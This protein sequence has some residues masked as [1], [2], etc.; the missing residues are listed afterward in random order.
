MLANNNTTSLSK[1][2]EMKAKKLHLQFGHALSYKIE[3]LLIDA[4]NEVNELVKSVYKFEEKCK[5]CKTFSNAKLRPAVGLSLVKEFNENVS[6]DLMD[7]E[8]TKILHI[9][10][11]AT[12]FST[13]CII[14]SK[15]KRVIIDKVFKFW[16]AVLDVQSDFF[17]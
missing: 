9:I 15:D 16:I 6:V 11:H 7:Y 8:G 17:R 3:E 5:I 1:N 10:A 12:R 14:P 2:R 13:T 4:D